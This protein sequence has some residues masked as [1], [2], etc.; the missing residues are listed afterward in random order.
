MKYSVSCSLDYEVEEETVFFFNLQPAQFDRQVILDEHLDLEGGREIDRFTMG[1]SGNRFFK[2]MASPGN[3]T[4]KYRADVDLDPLI[5]SPEGIG[6][7]APVDL[8][9]EVLPH[10]NPSRFCQSDRLGSFAARQFG[11][12]QPGHGQVTAI[13][14]W[15][16]ETLEYIPGTSHGTTS[17][18]DT[19]VDHAGVCRDF[20]HLGVAMCRALG[21]PAR[22]VSAYAFRL[23]P[24]DF[25]AV[26]EAFVG[27]RWYLFDAT[28]KAALDGLIRI[29]VGRDAAEV[30]FS[31][32]YGKAKAGDMKVSIESPDRGTDEELTTQAVSLSER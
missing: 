28:R 26:F 10:L 29:G 13:C 32:S 30:S 1:E 12:V 5:E 3:L 25:H 17:A 14:N 6:K 4:V 2:V 23:D 21:I 15:I 8:P 27:G 20:A 16:H 11:D 31:S 18:L 7:V 19:I 22:Y 9:L 24:P